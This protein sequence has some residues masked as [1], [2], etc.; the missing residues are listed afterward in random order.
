MRDTAAHPKLWLAYF[1]TLLTGQLGLYNLYIKRGG[2][3]IVMSG[4]I[5]FAFAIWLAAPSQITFFVVLAVSLALTVIWVIDLI[6]MKSL[7]ASARQTTDLNSGA[8]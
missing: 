6:R 2:S 1:L 4:S 3:A 8:S 5:I 7:V